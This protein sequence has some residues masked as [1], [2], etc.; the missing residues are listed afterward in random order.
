MNSAAATT[1]PRPHPM[2]R[3]AWEE[4]Y[5]PTTMLKIDESYQRTLDERRV[6]R[7]ARAWSD[8]RCLYLEVNKRASGEHYVMNGQHRLA[9][10]LL[11]GVEWL[12]CRVFSFPTVEQEALWYASQAQDTRPVA[13]LARMKARVRAGDATAVAISNLCK[14]YGVTLRFIGGRPRVGETRAAAALEEA[15]GRNAARLE[16]ILRILQ[17]AWADQDAA[18]ADMTLNGLW[19]FLETW[20][21]KFTEQRLVAVLRDQEPKSLRQRAATR[22]Q[23][24]G[25]GS[26]ERHLALMLAELY[27]KGLRSGRLRR[28]RVT[29]EERETRP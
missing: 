26:A 8:A 10:A 16:T 22:A 13:A 29:E 1:Q 19:F 20:E 7:I 23:L 5:L 9:A 2:S 3:E 12:P 21:E 18:I 14:R 4:N 17:R 25:G 6:A 28:P 24:A 15:Y 11:A 27:D